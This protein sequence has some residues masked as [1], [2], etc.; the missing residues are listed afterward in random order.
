MRL[1]RRVTALSASLALGLLG[2]HGGTATAQSAPAPRPLQWHACPLPD[3]PPELQ[4]ASIQ[5]PIDYAR[6]RSGT[7]TV[8]VDR[9]RA[10]D[11]AAR[12]GSLVFDPGGPGGSG[13]EIVYAE[14]L[15]IPLFTPAVRRHF[16]VI[17]LDPRGVGLSSPVL[18]DPGVLNLHL[19]LFPQDRHAFRDLRRADRELGR[20][21]RERTGRVV[22]HV[23]TASAARDIE[24][25]R[26]ALQE[27]PLNYLG[28]SYGSQLGSTYAAMYP[29]R[30]RAMVLDGALIHSA[31][32]V[33]LFTDE[34][35]AYED[36]LVRFARWC[37][38][39]TACV[40]HGRDVLALFD[41]LVR[42]AD[43]S[44]IPAAGCAENQCRPAVTGEDIRFAAQDLLLFPRPIPVIAPEGWNDLALALQAA[45]QGDTTAFSPPVVTSPDQATAAQLAIECLDWPEPVHNLGGL[46]ALHRLGERLAPHTGGASQ[47]W[48]ILAGCLRWPAKVVNPPAPLH[49]TGT[50]PVLIVN[51]THDPSTPYVWAQRLHREIVRSV[52]VTRKGDGHTSYLLSGASQTRDA[53]DRYL[54]DPTAHRTDVVYSS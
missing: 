35:R 19:S 20:S 47:S 38:S 8:T 23:D 12:I 49:V 51:A 46:E 13:T 50:P 45:E 42:R 17:G 21:C 28:L 11:P 34:V 25:L 4:C 44:P 9:L 10:T 36:S 24:A 7:T 32:P 16:D 43:R 15:G 18:C 22:E 1:P 39:T 29:D 54:V 52:L 41:R 27:G 53:I 2:G 30:I 3:A 48:T 33:Q 5:V 37:A 40:L 14:S 6:P 26:A 31:G